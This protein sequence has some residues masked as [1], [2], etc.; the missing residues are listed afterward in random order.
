MGKQIWLALVTLCCVCLT[1]SN[2]RAWTLACTQTDPVKHRY[3]CKTEVREY[4]ADARQFIRRPA[5]YDLPVTKPPLW[6]IGACG[7]SFY[8]REKHS[9]N[10]ANLGSRQLHCE[11]YAA[12]SSNPFGAGGYV[13]GY[14]HRNAT[15]LAPARHHSGRH[16]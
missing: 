7:S 8:G 1:G 4:H 5:T 6:L 9:V 13:H 2:V 12:G 14:C 10:C 16:R 15:D 3:L 11:W